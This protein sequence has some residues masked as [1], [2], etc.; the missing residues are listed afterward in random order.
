MRSPLSRLPL[1]AKIMLSTSVAL[2]A[3]FAITTEFV[4]NNI[5][6]TMSQ[7]LQQEVQTSFQAYQS[8]WQARTDL[9]SSAGRL[10]SD[11][12]DVRAAFGSNDKPTIIEKAGELWS[13]VSNLNAIFLV[14]DP[15]GQVLASLSGDAPPGLTGNLDFV[16][17]A[18]ET[19][20]NA[21]DESSATAPK[22]ASA[23]FIPNGNPCSLYQI[24]VTP[25]YVQS[26]PGEPL[27]KQNMLVAGLRIDALVAQNL[28][29]ATNSDFLFVSPG[30]AIASTLNGRATGV[31]N[32]SL[33]NARNDALVSDGVMEYAWFQTQ[34]KDISGKPVATLSILR[35]FETANAAVASLSTKIGVLWLLVMCAGLGFTYLLARRIV[36]PVKQLDRAAAEVARQNYA[37]EVEVR[38]DDELGR[39]ARTFNNMCASIRQAREDLIRQE[40][41]STIGRLSSSI[42]HDLRNP[43]AAIYGGSEMLVDA[44]LPPGHI[45]RLAGNIYR[46][47][48][49]IQELLQ[50][51]L[52]VSRGKT[53]TPELCRLREVA[54]A[55]CDSLAGAATAQAVTTRL[56][57]PA[58][59]EAPLDRNRMERAFVNLISNA[60]EAMPGGGEIRISA[61]AEIG[62]D[63]EPSVLVT[64]EDTGPGIA[65]EIRAKIFQPFVTA[66]K[67]NGLGLGLALTRQ[68]VLDHGGD[69]WVDSTP[70][71]GARFIFRLPGVRAVPV[72]V[73]ASR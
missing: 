13:K 7:S 16:R 27:R 8:L 59:L 32:S 44:D 67:R 56:S 53:G 41:I 62:G 71:R 70:G 42:V 43:L 24:S 5:R 17:Q 36:E 64:V 52:N 38:G 2:T 50:D 28:K 73:E 6:Q 37:I 12:P 26:T 30:C 10:M 57:I 14:A 69:M 63:G 47:S 15:M 29:A 72:P 55:A 51:L 9:V 46:A 48:R 35:P 1:L 4:L 45:K 31:V 34:L 18:A 20:P 65:P 66:G 54:F 3:L 39:L 68:T 25:V 58:D 49:R 21:I 60:L 33:A 19:F 22:T 40:R 61:T 11:M 23:Y